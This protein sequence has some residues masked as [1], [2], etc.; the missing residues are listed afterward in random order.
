MRKVDHSVNAVESPCHHKEYWPR[1]GEFHGFL[2]RIC[3]FHPRECT[4]SESATDS[5]VL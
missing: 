5:K 4:R 2:D 3:I 1:P